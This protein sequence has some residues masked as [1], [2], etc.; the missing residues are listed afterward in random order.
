[1]PRTVGILSPTTK[2]APSSSSAAGPSNTTHPRWS[3]N[4]VTDPIRPLTAPSSIS[5]QTNL[6][7]LPSLASITDDLSEIGSTSMRPGHYPASHP[8]TLSPI[9][10]DPRR[11]SVK[12]S[13]TEYSQAPTD[14]S[15]FGHRTSGSRPLS[16]GSTAYSSRMTDSRPPSA[17]AP[18]PS[19]WGP[20]HAP[21]AVFVDHPIAESS[22]AAASRASRPSSG[23][24][25]PHT[26]LSSID[27][28]IASSAQP[29]DKAKP[30]TSSTIARET[31]DSSEGSDD[32]SSES[33]SQAG[34]YSRVLVGLL[35][36]TCHKLTGMDGTTGLYFFPKTL[37]VRTEGK[38]AIKCTLVTFEA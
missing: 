8:N 11:D 2:K 17:T 19:G 1:M 7:S 18:S 3:S 35:A 38:F 12:S 5:Y 15:F 34:S 9:R 36:E 29:E 20:S 31:K 22:A 26:S 13:T 30:P 37:G 21:S 6:R 33:D 4:R 10:A 27:E 28:Q 16:S 32:A 23:Y 25:A 24:N 14:Y